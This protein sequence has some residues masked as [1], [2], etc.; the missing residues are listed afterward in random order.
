MRFSRSS[1]LKILLRDGDKNSKYFHNSASVRK[2]NNSVH[3]IWDVDGK[4]VE[5]SEMVEVFVSYFQKFF[6]ATSNPFD[7]NSVVQLLDRRVT[8]AMRLEL[9]KDFTALDVKVALDQTSVGKSHG[10]D[11]L[12]GSFSKNTRTLLVLR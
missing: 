7:M 4:W 11:G 2:C 1:D 6:T 9:D 12:L 3:Q 8:D 10:L 5:G